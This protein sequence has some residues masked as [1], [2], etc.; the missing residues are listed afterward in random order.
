MPPKMSAAARA[1]LLREQRLHKVRL[2][3]NSPR[4][5][6]A[7]DLPKA[8]V[9]LKPHQAAMVRRC[10]DIEIDAFK[11]RDRE[12]KRQ[13][14]VQRRRND[15]DRGLV[16][17]ERRAIDEE[18]Q[19]H[20]HVVEQLQR[21]RERAEDKK[22][23]AEERAVED[24]N[25][26]PLYPYGVMSAPVGCG[27][28]F[29]ILSLCL[30]DKF[31]SSRKLIPPWEFLLPGKKQSGATLIVI[32]S[33]L[34]KQ[35][36]DAIKQFVGDDLVVHRFNSYSDTVKMFDTKSSVIHRADVFLVSSLYYQALAT[37]LI[38]MGISFRRLVFD[39]ADSMSRLINYT[40]PAT[41]TW[42]VSASIQSLSSRNGLNIGSDGQFFV[43][44][45]V[46]HH[47]T[48]DCDPEFIRVSFDLPK[49]VE[50]VQV[51]DDDCPE[52]DDRTQHRKRMCKV[53]PGLLA[54]ERARRAFY[55]CDPQS[56]Q[57]Y[58]LG[59]FNKSTCGDELT[60][61]FAIA[62]GWRHKLQA[63]K[64]IEIKTEDDEHAIRALSV[65]LEA[66][67]QSLSEVSDVEEQKE[68]EEEEAAA[69]AASSENGPL[70]L[71]N[72]LI[73][74]KVERLIK[75]C[76]IAGKKK[77]LVFT[78]FPR[79]LYQIIP[80]LEA[81]GVPF[82]DLE[83]GGTME[84]MD[85]CQKEYNNGD[86]QILLTHSNMFSCGMNLENTD[87]VVFVHDVCPTLRQQVIGRAQR[88]GRCG[89]LLVTTLLYRAERTEAK[90]S[91][92]LAAQQ[93][94]QQGPAAPPAK[95]E[96]GGGGGSGGGC[97]PLTAQRRTLMPVRS[98]GGKNQ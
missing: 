71:A 93:Q 72:Q 76:R 29:S 84:K 6:P 7:V 21:K 19:M 67:L 59:E 4:I 52:D 94:Q 96:D 15:E 1:A 38:S 25:A 31:G 77:T 30:L 22:R 33:H 88:P 20:L 28:T 41:F 24:A 49:T 56:V 83:G 14:E 37:S 87:H 5:D 23:R 92:A 47:N 51:C 70:A 53:L 44:L 35:W 91:M 39:E 65:N 11:L 12:E 66:L 32:P 98:G 13:R 16:D 68:E 69:A 9:D 89:H 43:P 40:T 45:D 55:A 79:L 61:A 60:L 42:L 86:V 46:L 10:L 82:A 8:R 18:K 64:N 2:Q 57:V 80:L 74:F 58:E 75:L 50:G 73:F 27:K 62:D 54:D 36:D 78:Q 3:E 95:G 90:A 63:M 97:R 34:F 81:E 17:E 26:P 48:V 85:E